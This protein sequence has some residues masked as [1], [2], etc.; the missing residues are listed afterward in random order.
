MRSCTLF[1]I[2]IGLSAVVA[3][4]THVNDELKK[5]E[6]KWAQVSVEADGKTLRD[7]ADAA[8]VVLVISGDKWTEIAVADSRNSEPS[9]FKINPAKTPK[10][11]D[12]MMEFE[13]GKLETVPGIYKLDGDTLTTAAPFPFDGDFTNIGKRPTEFK[14][15]KG[16]GFVVIVY[17]RVKS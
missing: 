10:E 7:K 4:G 3:Q 5:L 8:K 14:T 6:G 9:K 1:V 12:I 17:N 2:A 15:K 16:D 11:I 13:K